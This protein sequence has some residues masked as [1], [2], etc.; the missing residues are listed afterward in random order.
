MVAY[1]KCKCGLTPVCWCFRAL[2]TGWAS[3]LYNVYTRGISVY[4]L[5]G[6]SFSITSYA[7][8]IINDPSTRDHVWVTDVS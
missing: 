3:E 8:V 7:C 6:G 1:G 2:R 5:H 4:R